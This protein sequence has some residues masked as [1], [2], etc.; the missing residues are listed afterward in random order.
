MDDFYRV[1]LSTGEATAAIAALRVVCSILQREG[2]ASDIA[3]EVLESAAARIEAE[4]PEFLGTAAEKLRT[5]LADTLAQANF[6]QFEPDE[7]SRQSMPPFGIGRTRRI[8][9]QAWR[10][11]GIA[12]IE[13]YVASRN[14]W[15]TRS[16]QISDVYESENGWYL[17][18]ECLLRK[19]HRMFRLENIRTA[20]VVPGVVSADDDLPDP[21]NDEGNA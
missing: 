21:F 6:D 5:L 7:S 4:I 10:S 8:L 13:Y 2:V 14:Q 17:E 20:R 1:P 19:D 3:P 18:G 9:E 12:E 11:S 16:V 15:S